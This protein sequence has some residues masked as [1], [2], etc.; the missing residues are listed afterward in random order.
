MRIERLHIEG[1]RNIGDAEIEFNHDGDGGGL[2]LLDE[3]RG[4]RW[5]QDAIQIAAGPFLR[6]MPF[7]SGC[8][9]RHV[10]GPQARLAATF[11]SPLADAPMEIRREAFTDKDGKLL[12][13]VRDALPLKELAEKLHVLRFDADAVL[14]L[15][16]FH[17]AKRR[18]SLQYRHDETEWMRMERLAVFSDAGTPDAGSGMF[19]QWFTD[20]WYSMNDQR[21]KRMQGSILLDPPRLA[22]YEALNKVVCD[23]VDTCLRPAGAEGLEYDL[24]ARALVARHNGHRVEIAEMPRDEVAVLGAVADLACRCCILNQAQAGRTLAA[25]PGIVLLDWTG[26]QARWL[27]EALAAMRRT[28]P[29]LQFIAALADA[30]AELCGEAEPA[31]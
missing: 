14:P 29:S 26:I 27:P 12:T 9:F 17:G 20:L 22:L 15:F 13:T 10:E 2:T 7:T 21:L 11:A 8:T 16:A 31:N 28:F 18:W 4:G 30:M 5:T 6:Q 25:T 19:A 3:T 23:A 24:D 1:F